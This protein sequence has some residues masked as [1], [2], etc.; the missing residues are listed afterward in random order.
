MPKSRTIHNQ[1]Y[2]KAAALLRDEWFLKKE[3]WL[4]VRFKEIGCPISKE[5]FKKYS[6]YLE[7]N[8]RFWKRYGE[9]ENGSEFKERAKQITCGKEMLNL[10]EYNELESFR[11][12]YLPPI[13]G[14]VFG[15]ILNHY[16]LKDNPAFKDFLEMYFFFGQKELYTSPFQVSM[17][18]KKDDTWELLVEIFPHTTKEDFQTHWDWIKKEQEFLFKDRIEKNKAWRNMER[19]LQVYTE[20]KKFRMDGKKRHTDPMMASDMFIYS[21]LANQWPKLT[22][23]LIRTIVTRTRKRLGEI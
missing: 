22:T 16:G 4:K 9:M 10:D 17:R 7:W 12:E 23:N 19:D 5:P 20:Y 18:R 2:H 15:E 1:D 21:E 11:K 8:D 14:Q 13:Y 6:E 3:A